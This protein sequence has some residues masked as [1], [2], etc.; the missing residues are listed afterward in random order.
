[1]IIM[2]KFDY[3]IKDP[4]GIHARPA[5]DLIK[6]VKGFGC[7]ITIEK[8]GKSADAGKIFAVMGLGA[9]SG[10][11]VTFTFDGEDEAEAMEAVKSFM[12]ANL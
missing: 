12:E 10:E 11:T 8:A 6:I 7:S 1:M 3:T 2:L 5:G 4:Q 9:K